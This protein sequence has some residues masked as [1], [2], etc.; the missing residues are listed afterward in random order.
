M[1]KPLP[2]EILRLTSY[3]A[4]AFSAQLALKLFLKPKAITRPQSELNYYESARRFKL[5]SGLVAYEWGKQ[6]NP[7]IFLI[8]GWEGRG[9]QMGAFSNDLVERGYR[10]IALDGPAHGDSEGVYTNAGEF[11]RKLVEAQN[12]LGPLEAV[13]AHSF[14]GGCSVIAGK[15]G[16][17]T[18]KLILI[19][20]PS[21]FYKVIDGFLNF[22]ELSDNANKKFLARLEQIAKINLNELNISELGKFL[23]IPILIVHD[24]QDKEVHFD[25]ALAFRDHLPHVELLA[26]EGLGHRRI[27]KELSVIK[28]VADFIKPI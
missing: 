15:F 2:L 13:I 1:K 11:S 14:G 23:Q 10:V 6:G 16:L 25:E 27:L 22:L 8:H 21:D 26:T 7:I 4:P 28:K 19:A 12:E 24:R 3:I 18:K 5:K 20:S 9:T 17:Q